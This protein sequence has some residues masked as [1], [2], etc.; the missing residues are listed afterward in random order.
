MVRKN[1]ALAK[2]EIHEDLGPIIIATNEA[3][4]LFR[5]G[6]SKETVGFVKPRFTGLKEVSH[7]ALGTFVILT[8]H[9]DQVL[10][11][12]QID[13]L[14]QFKVGIEKSSSM[15][16]N[17]EALKPE[18]FT[19]QE[20]LIKKT[21]AFLA[22][23]IEEKRV[24]QLDLQQFSR[25]TSANLLENADEAAAFAI[26]TIDSA[27]VKWHKAM[28]PEEWSK[29]HVI[30][31]TSHMPRQRSLL[32]QYFSKILGEKNECEK[33]IVAEGLTTDDQAIDLLL[34]HIL[35]RKLAVGFFN[36]P[37]RMHRDLLSDGAAKF[38]K[39]NE[40]HGSQP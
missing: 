14:Q 34:T 8:N 35:D 21:L 37:W 25:S 38:L 20:W 9:T 30:V 31:M 3:V 23:V 6:Q 32:I 16:K 36:D 40:L 22:K 15:I 33:I 27:M 5:P 17:S 2:A 39:R 11:Q 28:T 10:S 18:D 1:Y 4:S 29:L 19:R 26:E 13:R 12:A 7:L 24:S